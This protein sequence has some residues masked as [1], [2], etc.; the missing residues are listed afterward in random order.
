ML[1]TDGSGSSLLICR[2]TKESVVVVY[3]GMNCIQYTLDM[4]QD[5]VLKELHIAAGSGGRVR[6]A[7]LRGLSSFAEHYN[8]CADS[9]PKMHKC[10]PRALHSAARAFHDN[11][12]TE[13]LRLFSKAGATPRAM[14]S[15]DR[16]GLW[17][18]IDARNVRSARGVLR[19]AYSARADFH[20][21]Q[22]QAHLCP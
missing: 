1:P 20:R 5:N 7:A 13:H 17:T 16:S 9:S 2:K 19:C 3:C 11:I 18:F 10:M 8:P 4:V 22:H 6:I 14:A 21:T 12:R 15:G